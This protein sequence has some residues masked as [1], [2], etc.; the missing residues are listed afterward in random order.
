MYIIDEWADKD[1]VHDELE[2]RI[3]NVFSF[4]LTK[5]LSK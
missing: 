5:Q 2:T 3:L 1:I 4:E